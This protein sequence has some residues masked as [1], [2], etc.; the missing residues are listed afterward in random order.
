MELVLLLIVIFL[1]AAFGLLPLLR[2][3]M[4]TALWLLGAAL[5]V[6]FI[7]ALIGNT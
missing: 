3:I 2:F 1:V 4:L 5:I 6:T 7:L